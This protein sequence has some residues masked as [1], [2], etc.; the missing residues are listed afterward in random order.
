MC[1]PSR[2]VHQSAED[3]KNELGSLLITPGAVVKVHSIIKNPELEAK[4]DKLCAKIISKHLLSQL[5]TFIVKYV[6]VMA[7]IC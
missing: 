4:F 5:K 2:L 3:I 1:G 6:E 7:P